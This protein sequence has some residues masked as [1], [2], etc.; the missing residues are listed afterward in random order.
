MSTDRLEESSANHSA[1]PRLMVLAGDSAA[2]HYYVHKLEQNFDLTAVVWQQ[3]NRLRTLKMVF[4]RARRLGWF[5]PL[6]RILLGVYA[7]CTMRRAARASAAWREEQS[8]CDYQPRCP[9]LRVNSINEEAVVTAL[10]HY[11]PD[12]VLVWGTSI[13]RRPVLQFAACFVNVHAGITPM[14]RGAHGG[15]WAAFNDDQSHLGITLHRVDEGIDTGRIL[16]QALV[17]FDPASD[18]LLTLA[19]KQ[20]VAGAQTAVQWLQDHRA[21]F[22]SDPG[23][24][25]QPVGKSKLYYS[26]GFRDYRRFERQVRLRLKQA[27]SSAL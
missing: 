17:K 21:D 23:V 7:R 5:Y 26:P 16:Q 9:Q 6:D 18:N 4:R 3:P 13:I 19:A 20:T 12:L 22:A 1:S 14:Y 8:A 27:H 10:Q 15:F 24:L 11:R 2:G 25:A